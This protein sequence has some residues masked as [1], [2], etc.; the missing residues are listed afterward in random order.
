VGIE[1][2]GDYAVQVKGNTIADNPND[3]VL[4]FEY[5]NPFPPTEET[6]FF[7]FAANQISNNWF[8]NNGYNES[9]LLS[10]S[11]FTGDV[12][13]LS[14]YAELF[15]GPTSQSENNCV[16]ANHFSGATF[17]TGLDKTWGCNNKNTPNPGG[18]LPA[19]EYLLTLLEESRFIQENLIPPM[20]QPAPPKQPTMPNPC[21]GAPKSPLCPQKGK[22]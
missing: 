6:I 17:P 5:P 10:G 2:P 3:G 14:G 20:G 1:L 8:Q 16:S 7:Q 4:G 15:G 22:H 9:P 19:A 12:A 13:L 11:P 18:G 21:K